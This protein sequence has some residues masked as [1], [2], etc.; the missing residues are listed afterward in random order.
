MNKKLFCIDCGKILAKKNHYVKKFN[1]R[2]INR[3]RKCSI[4]HSDLLEKKWKEKHPNYQKEYY[5]KKK[6]AK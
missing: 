2:K 5:F 6:N 1:R 3:C 4:L